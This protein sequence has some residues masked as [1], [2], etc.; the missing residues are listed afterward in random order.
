[1][2]IA[3]LK[4]EQMLGEN[5]TVSA[6]QVAGKLLVLVQLSDYEDTV[7]IPEKL[8]LSWI[9]QCSEGTSVQ[10]KE[11]LVDNVPVLVGGIGF[12]EDSRGPGC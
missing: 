1:M 10:F 2:K 4:V 9:G 5:P 11:I 3:D 12:Y 6:R 8:W 7:E